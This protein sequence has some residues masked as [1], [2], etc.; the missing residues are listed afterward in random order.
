MAGQEEGWGEW[1]GEV[2]LL[3]FGLNNM[4]SF[5]VRNFRGMKFSRH[6]DFASFLNNFLISRFSL[7]ATFCGI[8]ILRFD[9]NTIICDIL[10]S[11]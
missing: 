7:N 2:L 8:L 9:Q 3:T 10:V 4:G 1:V 6:F 5:K 11:Q